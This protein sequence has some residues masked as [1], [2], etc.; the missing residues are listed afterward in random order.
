VEMFLENSEQESVD[1]LAE[2]YVLSHFR[3]AV[4]DKNWRMDCGVAAYD[5]T[6]GL[7]PFFPTRLRFEDYIYR[8]WIQ[9]PGIAAAHVA[10]AQNHIKSPYM[11]NPLASEV[12]NE[13]V[14]NFLKRKILGSITELS[15]V[16]IGFDYDGEV[17][18][19]EAASI[20]E[21]MR[22]LHRRVQ[23][24]P[25]TPH[26]S[27]GEQLN[28]LAVTLEHTF[29]GFQLDVFQYNLRRLLRSTV[30]AIKS[31]LRLWPLLLEICDESA[32]RHHLPVLRIC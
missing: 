17:E 3:P 12:L 13:E 5:N 31:S 29:F 14:A 23:Q 22:Q 16:T 32:R 20:L 4:T 9:R 6:A 24:A 25:Q 2:I 10:A 1:A 28:H 21:R 18:I 11:R 8:L 15:E 30:D 7:P 26:T 27:R 19:S